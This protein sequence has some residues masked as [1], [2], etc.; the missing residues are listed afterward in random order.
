M[1][2]KVK[3]HKIKITNCADGKSVSLMT[4][5]SVDEVADY[6]RDSEKDEIVERLEQEVGEV[7]NKA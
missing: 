2:A 3:L 7:I 6:I 4:I 1:E 5:R